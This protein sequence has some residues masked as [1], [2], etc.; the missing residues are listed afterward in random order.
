MKKS[1]I[2]IFIV[3]TIIVICVLEFIFLVSNAGVYSIKF[4]N[5]FSSLDKIEITCHFIKKYSVEMIDSNSLIYVGENKQQEFGELGKYRFK[6]YINDSEAS[7]NFK[8]SF[9]Y[10]TV[11]NI[12]D[13]DDFKFIYTNLPETHAIEIYIGSNTPFSVDKQVVHG[14]EKLKTKITIPI[15]KNTTKIQGQ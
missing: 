4:T 15:K 2:I 9:K 14:K 3:L 12:P 13:N 1:S 5:S 7:K 11:Y 8:K 6:I 10:C